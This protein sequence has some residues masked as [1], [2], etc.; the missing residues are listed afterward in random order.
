[1]YR[2]WTKIDYQDK[3]C[4]TDQTDKGTKDDRRRDGRT[5]FTWRIKEQATCITSLFEHDDDEVNIIQYFTFKYFYY[6][7]RVNY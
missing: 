3:H 1:M 7:K 2:G 4:S 5:N 6:Y